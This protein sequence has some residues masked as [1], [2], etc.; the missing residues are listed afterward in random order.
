[1]LIAAIAAVAAVC[2][3]PSSV[4]AS[5]APHLEV[6]VINGTTTLVWGPSNYEHWVVYEN[7]VNREITVKKYNE[8]EIDKGGVYS[9]YP[10]VPKPGQTVSYRVRVYTGASWSNEVTITWP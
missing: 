4:V 9:E 1:M 10:P 2:T 7:G 3:T 6:Q 8:T 5:P